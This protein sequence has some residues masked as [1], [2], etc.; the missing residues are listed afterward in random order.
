[1]G[2]GRVNNG[3]ATGE[4][5]SMREKMPKVAAWIDELRAAFGAE[6]IDQAIRRGM[7][8]GLGTGSAAGF[9]AS[10]ND[11]VIGVAPGAD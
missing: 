4:V 10:E 5:V 2:L 3:T 7:R 11:H 8:E 9:R 1:M 6:V